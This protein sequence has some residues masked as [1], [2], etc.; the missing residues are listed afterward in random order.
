MDRGAESTRGRQK[1]GD[2]YD[3][4][5]ARA[6]AHTLCARR[7]LTLQE[8]S[9]ALSRFR[10]AFVALLS[11][12]ARAE[13]AIFFARESASSRYAN[14]LRR[15]RNARGAARSFTERERQYC[16]TARKTLT[17]HARSAYI[18]TQRVPLFASLS[19]A[20]ES[21]RSRDTLRAFPACIFI[22]RRQREI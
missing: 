16:N 5:S 22:K 10:R 18:Y 9:P 6:R 4:M 14:Q 17:G 7:R 21:H 8:Y 15:V 19:A 3:R 11:R 2:I 1:P 20:R 12:D 13:R